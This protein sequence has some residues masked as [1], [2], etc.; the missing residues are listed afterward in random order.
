MQQ[1]DTPR[2]LAMARCQQQQRCGYV[3]EGGKY[4]LPEQCLTVVLAEQQ[5]RLQPYACP[6]STDVPQ[7][8]GCLEAVRAMDCAFPFSSFD[9]L[10]ECDPA[11][12][13]SGANPAVSA[14]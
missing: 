5:D 7:L 2:A 11:R 9:G 14:P 6:M 12:V 3:R 8:Q 4:V 10:E 1:H 13:C